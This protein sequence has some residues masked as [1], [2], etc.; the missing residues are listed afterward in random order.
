MR[1]KKIAAI[2]DNDDLIDQ[3]QVIVAPTPHE[4][5]TIASEPGEAFQLLNDVAFDRVDTDV[6][7]VPR[8]PTDFIEAIGLIGITCA[9][10]TLDLHA[11]RTANS[12]G[13]Q[14]HP[15]F[16][17]TAITLPNPHLEVTISAYNFWQQ[18]EQF[19]SF[20]DSLD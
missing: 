3:L 5:V 17:P 15:R 11:A 10:V 4:V 20:L 1:E 13:C 12:V 14:T 2:I 6:L 9:L 18:P 8:E 16:K 19:V 7:L